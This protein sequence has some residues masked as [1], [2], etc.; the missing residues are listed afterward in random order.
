MAQSVRPYTVFVHLLDA[1]GNLLDQQDGWPVD[2]QW[3]PTC[4]QPDSEV[5]DQR[6]IP[7]SAGASALRIGLYDAQTGVRLLT[8]D[9]QDGVMV[10]V[11]I[12]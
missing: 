7:L 10:T 9:G 4:W 12:R 3:P 1:E 5:L 11:P 2:G 8:G 6:Q